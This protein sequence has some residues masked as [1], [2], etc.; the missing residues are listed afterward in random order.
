MQHTEMGALSGEQ[1]IQQSTLHSQ[2]IAAWLQIF[3]G[4]ETET[5][6]LT[7]RWSTGKLSK[8]QAGDI[9]YQQRWMH[10]GNPPIMHS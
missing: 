2:T 3:G 6:V 4:H 8:P 10:G 7:V 5:W 1:L 9:C